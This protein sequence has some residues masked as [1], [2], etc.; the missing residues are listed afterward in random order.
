VKGK[1]AKGKGRQERE[2]P[3]ERPKGKL[4]LP[5][6]GKRAKHKLNAEGN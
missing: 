4:N 3:L 2:R 1:R 5:A 6:A